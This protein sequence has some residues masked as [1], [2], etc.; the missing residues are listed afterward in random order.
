VTGALQDS[1]DLRAGGRAL[2]VVHRRVMQASDRYWLSI[3]S[4]DR[5]RE[6]ESLARRHGGEWA[7][8][9]R[10]VEDAQGRL[11]T[12]MTA[13][14]EELRHAWTDL[15]ERAATGSISST[16]NAELRGR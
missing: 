5:R 8:W 6:L 11:P 4:L 7:A 13:V 3:A 14:N 1:E 15:V 16:A 2:S 12:G 10:S 9:A